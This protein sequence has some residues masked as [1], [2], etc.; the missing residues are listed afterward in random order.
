MSDET[1]RELKNRAADY[2]R[3]FGSEQG[4]RCLKD[5]RQAYCTGTFDPNPFMMAFKAGQM[6][7]VKDIEA[8]LLLGKKPALI[9]ELFREVEDQNFEE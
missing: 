8:Q 3:T 1:K 7:V 9:E 4:K 5:M 2:L 6:Q